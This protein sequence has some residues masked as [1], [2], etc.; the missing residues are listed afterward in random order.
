MNISSN[1]LLFDGGADIPLG[2]RVRIEVDWPIPSDVRI[3]LCLQAK[4]VRSTGNQ[5]A[6]QV[7]SY[8]FS[9]LDHDSR[10]A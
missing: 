6:V 8:G 10:A 1:G 4:V 5:I 3:S 7:S 2:T 9:V